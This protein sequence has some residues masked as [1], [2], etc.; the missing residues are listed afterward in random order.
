MRSFSPRKEKIMMKKMKTTNAKKVSKSQKKETLKLRVDW[1]KNT[2]TYKHR[3]EVT[4]S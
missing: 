1:G 2:H 3:S 4:F